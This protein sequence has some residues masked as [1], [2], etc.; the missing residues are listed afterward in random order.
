MKEARKRKER[1][2]AKDEAFTLFQT[3][4]G[5]ENHDPFVDNCPN[6]TNG[7]LVMEYVYR[8]LKHL[9]V[10]VE[11]LWMGVVAHMKIQI[12]GFYNVF[13]SAP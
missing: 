4:V 11:W 5:E 6:I 10:Y 8:G 3:N 2:R 1:G 9:L 12:V 13:L 7:I